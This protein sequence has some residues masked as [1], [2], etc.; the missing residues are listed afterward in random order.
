MSLLGQGRSLKSGGLPSIHLDHCGRVRLI[1]EISVVIRVISQ[2]WV[3]II[4]IVNLV[5]SVLG[6]KTSN[7]AILSQMV[8]GTT[9]FT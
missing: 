3:E 8:N 6:K 5:A 7:L 1:G 4:D 2:S 9:Y